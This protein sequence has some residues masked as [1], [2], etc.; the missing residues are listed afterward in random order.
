MEMVAGSKENVVLILFLLLFFSTLALAV[1][2]NAE[3][4]S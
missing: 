4:P 1:Y 3:R 2:L